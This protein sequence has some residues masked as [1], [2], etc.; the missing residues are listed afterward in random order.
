MRSRSPRF[1]LLAGLTTVVAIF[2]VAKQ[3]DPLAAGLR[4][5]YFA[6]A[7]WRST[8]IQSTIGPPPS[9]NNLIAA[10]RSRPPAQFSATWTGWL[11]VLRSGTYQFATASDDGSWV[12]IDGQEVVSNGGKHA[13]RVANGSVRL[14]R[15]MH[16][17]LVKY[18]QD[19]GGLELELS[20]ARQGEALGPLAAWRLS[21]RGVSLSRMLGSV[22]IRRGLNLV[23]WL[24]LGALLIVGVAALRRPVVRSIEVLREDRIRFALAAL[25]GCS[26]VL[27]LV[28]IRWGVPSSWAGDEITPIAVFTGLS[29]RFSGGWF[30]R[31]PPLHFYLLTAVS[32]PSLLMNAVGFTQMSERDLDAVLIVLARLVSVAAGVGTLI[33]VYL[34]GAR[35][36][37]K[38]AGVFAVGMVSVL[39]PFIY[40]SKTAN[41]EVPY[42]FWFSVSLIFYLRF[43]QTLSLRDI[44]FFSIA[45]SLSMCTKDQAYGLYLASPL[46]IVYALWRSNRDRGLTRPLMHAVL[47]LRV[48]AA[49]ATVMACFVAIYILPF[50]LQGF[51]SHV[52]DITGPGSEPW[53]TFEP[54]WRGRS[55]LLG[56]NLMLNR[57]S[58][59]WPLWIA[60]LIGMALALRERGTRRAAIAL[61]LMIVSYYIGFINLILYTFDR[62]L[63]PVCVIEA[64]FGG[65]ALDRLLAALRGPSR[66]W[67]QALVAGAFVY[68]LLYAA[69]VDVLMIRDSRYAAE[70][71]LRA[72]VHGGDSVG[73]VFP[74]R[75][76]PRLDGISA[77]DMGT[78]EEL[79]SG[80]PAYFILNADYAR[81]IPPATPLGELIAGLQRQSLGYH[82]AF[83]YRAPAPW[84][85]LGG[86]PDLVGPRLEIS[87]LSI[88]RDIN[89]T[90][91]I[92]ARD[93]AG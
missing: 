48:A 25:I 1:W 56:V 10:W 31:Y 76:L 83:R 11:L 14:E 70:R 68:T 51:I 29:Q 34:C 33:A 90:I 20:W 82:L 43:L 84:P 9:T 58:W 57:E 85:W 12:Y 26:L 8:P 78:I 17:V 40:Y 65:F 71:W 47:D 74:T 52:R 15:G 73:I 35:A 62:Y 6:D 87:V 92:Y 19:G 3:L 63:L 42:T 30:D 79:R 46:V 59:G 45:A 91:E 49:A 54:T 93:P 75:V 7:D 66:A 88:L 22:V 13:T 81:A 39:A 86:H 27:D 67:R 53:R 16:S 77:S 60:S 72:R 24:W 32:S 36:F 64:L 61:L 80:R 28:G 37:G 21:P 23:G 18:F 41:P 4:V 69:T 2:G 38:R 5:T 89:P 44:V 50:N 55:A